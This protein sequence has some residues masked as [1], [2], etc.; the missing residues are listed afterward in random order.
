MLRLGP[1]HGPTILALPAL[2][3]EANRTRTL[4]VAV[5]R[6]L[7]DHGIAG[8]LPDLP[9]QGDSPLP[10]A[11]ARLSTWREAAAAAAATLP[12]PIHLVAL[13]GGAMAA[14]TI[15]AAS[16]WHLSP[17]TGAEQARELRRLRAA[18]G[19]QDYA[20]NT[21]ADAMIDDLAH[22]PL[23]DGARTR[24][25]RLAGDPRPADRHLAGAPPWRAAEAVADPAL[26]DALAQDIAAWIA[27]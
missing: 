23:P 9:G 11:A 12:G 7:A 24:V 6:R 27:G 10:T 18:G 14:A 26:A 1:D 2:F 3:E 25:V 5:L 8:A 16:G 22:A 21:I 19:S 13:R 17:L 15:A 4:L 20:G